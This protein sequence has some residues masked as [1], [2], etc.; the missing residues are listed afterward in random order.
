VDRYVE[1]GAD[2]PPVGAVDA[3]PLVDDGQVRVRHRAGRGCDGDLDELEQPSGPR[4]VEVDDAARGERR[5]EQPR[6]GCQVGLHRAVPVEVVLGEVGVG[7]DREA[8]PVDASEV[9]PVGGHLH[10]DRVDPAGPHPAQQPLQVRPSGVVRT[11]GWASPWIRV[12]IVPITPVPSAAA[13][14]APSS[15]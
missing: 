11:P 14:N 1:V 4:T 10:R 3:E 13:A 7:R 6:L 8:G 5:R 12:S 15:R 9:E 2:E